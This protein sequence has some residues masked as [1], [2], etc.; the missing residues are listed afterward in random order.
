[1]LDTRTIALPLIQDGGGI[2][3]DDSEGRVLA[4]DRHARRYLQVPTQVR[5][6]AAMSELA[7]EVRHFFVDSDPG[8]RTSPV[9]VRV[10]IPIEDV[11]SSRLLRD[12][13]PF[14]LAG[15]RCVRSVEL[16]FHFCEPPKDW[17]PLL[18]WLNTFVAERDEETQYRLSVTGPFPRLSEEVKEALSAYD[19]RL[20]Y[21]VGWRPGGSSHIAIDSDCLT[22]LAK[23][24]FRVPLIG[25]VDAVNISELRA[26]L[27]PVLTGNQYS[28][29]SL[30][31]VL[32][33]PR[34]AFRPTD[35]AI[36]DEAAYCR[37]LH[38]VYNQFP[39]Y[40]DV[41]HPIEEL[42]GLLRDG[43]WSGGNETP[44]RLRVLISADG[45]GVY[46]LIP[47]LARHWRD[48]GTITD[49]GLVAERIWP[50]LLQFH[51]RDC[52][53][54]QNPFCG[55]CNWRFVCGGLDARSGTRQPQTQPEGLSALCGGRK[56]FLRTL[57]TEAFDSV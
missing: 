7:A 57:A 42:A 20:A 9:A 18:R 21:T 46:Q 50:E 10:H 4:L 16:A 56:L 11:Y 32:Q 1:M 23:H 45:I 53:W 52:T 40:D 54:A 25:Y 33:H 49:G 36:P 39:H 44:T 12:Q 2:V 28:G 41:F 6:D 43:G 13:L 14:F 27:G 29:F 24:G 47:A 31:L 8:P 34:Y 22:D 51:R 15:L 37:L 5:D 17:A 35:P 38:E 30:P 26:A 19:V 55:T 48:W 3:L